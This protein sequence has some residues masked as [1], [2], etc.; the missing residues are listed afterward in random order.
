MIVCEAVVLKQILYEIQ[1]RSR[2]P[3]LR[4]EK[5]HFF[6]GDDHGDILQNSGLNLNV[7]QAAVETNMGT[8]V[9]ASL[10]KFSTDILLAIALPS[11]VSHMNLGGPVLAMLI[12]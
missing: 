8:T 9:V 12:V 1:P 4:N 5:L 11:S 2:D 10:R 7:K 6:F 3:V